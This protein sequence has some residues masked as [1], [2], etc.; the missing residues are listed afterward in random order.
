[1]QAK[2]EQYPSDWAEDTLIHPWER[3]FARM[4]DTTLHGWLFFSVFGPIF[5]EKQNIIFYSFLWCFGAALINAAIMTQGT[6]FGK[7]LF[8]IRVVDSNLYP[9]PFNILIRRELYVFVKGFALGIPVLNWICTYIEYV[10]L[11]HQGQASW[12]KKLG[13][14]LLYRPSSPR[15]K[16]LRIIGFIIFCICVVINLLY[17]FVAMIASLYW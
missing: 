12:D 13:T 14:K 17:V 16:T 9:L 5:G 1:M 3:Y 4:I 15:Q 10:T 7:W 6:T 2:Q 8:G 11:L